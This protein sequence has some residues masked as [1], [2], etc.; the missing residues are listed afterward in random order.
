MARPNVTV[1]IDDQSFIVP[2][3]EDGSITVGGLLSQGGFLMALGNTAER[4]QGYI[5]GL[6][7]FLY[8]KKYIINKIGSKK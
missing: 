4:K 5:A 7:W 6:E 8:E 3:T 2:G 1:L